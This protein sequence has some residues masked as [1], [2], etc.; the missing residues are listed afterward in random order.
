MLSNTSNQVPFCVVNHSEKHSALLALRDGSCTLSATLAYAC[1]IV[2]VVLAS[3]QRLN[4]NL[5]TSVRNTFRFVFCYKLTSRS[6]VGRILGTAGSFHYRPSHVGKS[7][8]AFSLSSR[9]LQE[10]SVLTPPRYVVCFDI[11]CGDV[12]QEAH[13]EYVLAQL[14]DLGRGPNQL[15]HLMTTWRYSPASLY[16]WLSLVCDAA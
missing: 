16:V 2:V 13:R 11:S 3:T 6:S 4:V 10:T 1:L 8:L 15:Y 7:M 14:P 5:E 12:L 9:W